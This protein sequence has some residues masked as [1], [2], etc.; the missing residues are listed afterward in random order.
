MAEPTRRL[1]KRI[2]ADFEPGSAEKVTRRLRNLP[3][4]AFGGQDPERVQAA[5]VLAS[6]G[7]WDRFVN[8]L[9]LLGQDWRDVLVS[10][11]LAHADWPAKLD[12]ELSDS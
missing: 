4:E 10:G 9:H 6:S 7:D 12:I 3:A 11:E 2:N 1:V 5:L 8:R